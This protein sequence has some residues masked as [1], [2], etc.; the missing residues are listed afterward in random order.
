[1]YEYYVS[2]RNENSTEHT[3]GKLKGN[4]PLNVANQV[5]KDILNINNAKAVKIKE[6]S[7]DDFRTV[8]CC[9]SY[10]NGKRQNFYTLQYKN[11]Y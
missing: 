3:V 4:N 11:K 6:E 9:T 5:I 1:M 8:I 7:I 10:G 2:Y